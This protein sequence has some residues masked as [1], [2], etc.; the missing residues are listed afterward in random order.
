[1]TDFAGLLLSD[2]LTH[3]NSKG[4]SGNMISISL[5]WHPVFK[6]CATG[7]A[8]MTP[9]KSG[10]MYSTLMMLISVLSNKAVLG[11]TYI[12]TIATQMKDKAKL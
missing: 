3:N 1:M 9:G 8:A 4:I 2:H 6:N 12:D 10:L 11:C 7:E 5:I